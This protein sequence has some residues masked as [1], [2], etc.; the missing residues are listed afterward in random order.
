M[1]D[2]TEEIYSCSVPVCKRFSSVRNVR[3]G[4]TGTKTNIKGTDEGIWRRVRLVPFVVHIPEED[5]GSHHLPTSWR[6]EL[7]GI[8]NWALEGL[9]EWR[10]TGLGTPPSVKDATIAFQEEMDS[11]QQFIES[12]VRDGVGI[13]EEANT[14][15]AS[16]GAGLQDK[17]ITQLNE[18]TSQSA[19]RRISPRI[20][21]KQTHQERVSG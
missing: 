18:M 14:S 4:C 12:G 5:Q 17:G 19:T 6:K 3:S 21:T 15:T 11:V 16:I 8:L 9:K 1:K 20:R 7:P 13:L 2:I 10:V